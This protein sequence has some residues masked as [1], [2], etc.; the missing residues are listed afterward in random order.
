MGMDQRRLQIFLQPLQAL[1][2]RPFQEPADGDLADPGLRGDRGPGFQPQ[3]RLVQDQ[4]LGD[5]G[6]GPGQAGDGAQPGS[7]GGV[8]GGQV[9]HDS[10]YIKDNE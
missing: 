5:H 6:L 3:R 10:I 7:K 8:F 1:V 2:A 4:P 9:V